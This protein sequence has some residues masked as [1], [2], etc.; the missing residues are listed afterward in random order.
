LSKQIRKL[1]MNILAKIG[2]AI[3]TVEEMETESRAILGFYSQLQMAESRSAP[4]YGPNSPHRA[5]LRRAC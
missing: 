5:R 1:E 2:E 4:A 3:E